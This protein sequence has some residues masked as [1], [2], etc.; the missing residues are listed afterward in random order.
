[1]KY[2]DKRLALKAIVKD[3]SASAEKRRNAQM[4]LQ[5]LPPDAS[6]TRLRNRCVITGR[7]NGVYRRFGLGRNKLRESAMQGYIPGLVKSSW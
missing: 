6:P 4:A 3:R 7:A 2:K 5:S 1:M